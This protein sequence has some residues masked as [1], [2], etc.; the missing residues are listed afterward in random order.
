VLQGADFDQFHPAVILTEDYRPKDAEKYRLLDSLGYELREKI[1]ADSLWTSRRLVGGASWP[2][3]AP[4]TV[5]PVGPS[6]FSARNERGPG[7]SNVE[8]INKIAS[9]V[10]GWA[11]AD[12][13]A[14]PPPVVSLALRFRDSRTEHYKAVRYPRVDVSNHFGSAKLYFAGFRCY[15]PNSVWMQVATIQVIQI[16]D[17]E[18]YAG[19]LIDV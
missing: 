16:A 1:G 2:E 9:F 3:H 14:E 11:I 15:L 18:I 12:A 17:S 10:R 13:S 19:A 7:T 6:A 4:T 5:M 8:E